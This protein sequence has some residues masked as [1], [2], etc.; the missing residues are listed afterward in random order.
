MKGPLNWVV[1]LCLLGAA[2]RAQDVEPTTPPIAPDAATAGAPPANSDEAVKPA[3]KCW[4]SRV[5]H[6]FGSSSKKAEPQMVIK[7]P[8]LKGLVLTVQVTPQTVKLSEVRQL[9]IKAVLTND[10]KRAIDLTFET[11]QRIEIY[12]KNSAEVILAKWSDNHAVHEKLGTVLINPDEH[13]EYN[14]TIATR[15]LTPDKVYIAEVFFPK[16]PELRGRQ[17]FLTAP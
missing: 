15:E 4:M 9:G 6:P 11:D 12:L 14:E 3:K 16:Y 8:K 5:L 1:C 2:A 17:K 10:G 7:D 13:I